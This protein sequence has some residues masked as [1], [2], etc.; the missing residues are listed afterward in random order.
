MWKKKGIEKYIEKCLIDPLLVSYKHIVVCKSTL[1]Y[2]SMIEM[3]SMG[4]IPFNLQGYLT[5]SSKFKINQFWKIL[6]NIALIFI[7]CT[8]V[9]IS[10]STHLMSCLI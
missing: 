10:K 3:I 6:N 7:P 8:L 9:S 2:V 1:F 5:L 4:M